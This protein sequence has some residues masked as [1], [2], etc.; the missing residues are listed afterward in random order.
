MVERLNRILGGCG[1]A[2]QSASLSVA[3][4]AETAD[5]AE[6]FGQ[7]KAFCEKETGT[8]SGWLCFTDRVLIVPDEYAFA[9]SGGILLSGELARGD[10]SLHIRQ[11]QT[12]WQLWH[13]SRH[14]GGEMLMVK[15]RF[16]S[17]RQRGQKLV[18]E[19]Y[20]RMEAGDE[21]L[22]VYRPFAARFAGF[23]QGGK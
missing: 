22:K 21:G 1:L 15:E 18:Y 9:D 12:G 3:A 4:T 23:E 13:L 19:K 11:S 10:E 20:W 2:V 6:V 8:C 17:I 16:V 14:D 7:A 5:R